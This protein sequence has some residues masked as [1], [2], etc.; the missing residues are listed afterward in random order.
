MEKEEIIEMSKN[1]SKDRQ[2][3]NAY[4]AGFQAVCNIIR[5]KINTCDNCEFCD[6]ME[7]LSYISYLDLDCDDE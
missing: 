3:Q 4:K 2:Q 5:E 1:Y 7:Q 6:E